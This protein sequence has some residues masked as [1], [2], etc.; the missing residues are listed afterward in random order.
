MLPC[1][2]TRTVHETLYPETL[3]AKVGGIQLKVEVPTPARRRH[4]K[5]AQMVNP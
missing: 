2:S 1:Y 5:A 4:I 3:S